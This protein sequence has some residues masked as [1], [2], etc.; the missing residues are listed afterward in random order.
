M[1]ENLKIFRGLRPR[2]LA[3]LDRLANARHAPHSRSTTLRAAR[4]PPTKNPGYVPD[5]NFSQNVD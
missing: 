1:H 2:T 4:I 3:E 5:H